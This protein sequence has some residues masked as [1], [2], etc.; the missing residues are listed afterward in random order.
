MKAKE[1]KSKDGIKFTLEDKEYELK[2]NMN[3]FCELEDVYE[4]I[5]QAFEDL[6]KMKLKAVRA[7]IYA[8]VKTEDKTATL[9]GVGEKLGIDDL[10]RLANL[11][12]EGLDKAMPELDEDTLGE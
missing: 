4:D 8:A 9:K 6:K 12:N 11:I 10:E 2:F 3:T 7:L 5:N 1:L